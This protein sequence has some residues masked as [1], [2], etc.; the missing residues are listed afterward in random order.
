MELTLKNSNI[1]E[2][3]SKVMV[4]IPFNITIDVVVVVVITTVTAFKSSFQSC[5]ARLKK[6]NVMHMYALC[7]ICIYG[8][9]QKSRDFN[10]AVII[11]RQNHYQHC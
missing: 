1:E 7:I 6:I 8:F 5:C 10:I 2:I 9:D 3:N 4:V 11:E